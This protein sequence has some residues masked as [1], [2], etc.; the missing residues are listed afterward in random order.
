MAELKLMNQGK[1]EEKAFPG[2]GERGKITPRKNKKNQPPSSFLCHFLS[3]FPYLF[4]HFHSHKYHYLSSTHPRSK[5]KM[6]MMQQREWKYI[7]FQWD[8]LELYRVKK[9]HTIDFVGF[10]NSTS[11]HHFQ[12]THNTFSIDYIFLCPQQFFQQN[13]RKLS[14]T[15][16]VPE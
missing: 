2:R 1:K 8:E 6:K 9:G 15:Y 4:L 10:C 13:R 7:L 5:K 12:H 14:E 16:T 11:T 3:I